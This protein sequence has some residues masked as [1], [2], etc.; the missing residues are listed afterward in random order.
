MKL[1]LQRT[2]T[3]TRRSA[4]LAEF[5]K[6]HPGKRRPTLA[7]YLARTKRPDHRVSDDEEEDEIAGAASSE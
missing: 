7:E 1:A 5:R 3:A 2:S 6:E 4:L